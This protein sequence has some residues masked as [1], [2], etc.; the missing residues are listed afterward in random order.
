MKREIYKTPKHKKICAII[1]AFGTFIF[2][3]GMYFVAHFGTLPLAFIFI[4]S[5]ICIASVCVERY[6]DN[7]LRQ[8]GQFV[9]FV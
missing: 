7:Q 6:K 2:L 8:A 5:V 9:P 3:L 4:G 1:F